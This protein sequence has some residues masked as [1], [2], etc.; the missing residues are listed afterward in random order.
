MVRVAVEVPRAKVL[1]TAWQRAEIVS[2]LEEKFGVYEAQE[3]IRTLYHP[4]GLLKDLHQAACRRGNIKSV[5][6]EMNYARA[7]R[8]AGDA[9]RLLGML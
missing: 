4:W 9:L 8:N 7:L 6:T 1:V 2:A 5:E 3:L